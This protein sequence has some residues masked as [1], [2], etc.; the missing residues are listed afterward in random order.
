MVKGDMLITKLSSWQHTSQ[1]SVVST[2]QNP[3]TKQ[4]NK[5]ENKWTEGKKKMT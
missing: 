2:Q 3:Q 4:T 1:D 5:P